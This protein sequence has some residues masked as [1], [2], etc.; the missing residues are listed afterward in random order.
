M[1]VPRYRAAAFDALGSDLE[2][3]LAN[4]KG[5]FGESSQAALTMFLGLRVPSLVTWRRKVCLT[6]YVLCK[7]GPVLIKVIL[8]ISL[9][10]GVYPTQLTSRHSFESW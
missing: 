1:Q 6:Q 9:I 4:V 5:D 2:V 10:R 7:N 8:E 3:R